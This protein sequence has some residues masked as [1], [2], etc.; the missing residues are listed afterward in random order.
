MELDEASTNQRTSFFQL[1]LKNGLSH[2]P[3][4]DESDKQIVNQAPSNRAHRG[5]VEASKQVTMAQNQI[6][7]AS[8]F[9]M[10]A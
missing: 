7:Q 10:A 1:L 3:H 4:G 8:I 6:N 2:R 5:R 9:L